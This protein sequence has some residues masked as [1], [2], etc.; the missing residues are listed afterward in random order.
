M[1]QENYFVS[2]KKVTC[3][4]DADLSHLEDLVSKDNAVIITD[5]H[6]YSGHSQKLDGWKTILIKPGEQYKQQATVEHL[7]S[8]LIELK[9]DRQTFIIGIGGGVVTD[10]TGYVASVY[11]RGVKFGFV[12]TTILAMTDAALGG[13]NGVDVGLYKNL[14]GTINQPEFLLYDY[15]FLS[16]LPA[17][18]WVNG[19]AEII[20]HAC[21]KDE[22]LF[23]Y[24]EENS[25]DF[26]KASPQKTDL[27]IKTNVAIKY[28][29]VTN[30]EYETGDRKL[31]NFG[32]TLGHA[33]EN[34]YTLPHGHAV[35]IGIAA[36]CTISEQL[37]NFPT[38]QTARIISLL[39]RYNLPVNIK[40]DKDKI[41]EMLLLD[42][43]KAKGSMNFILLNKIGEAIIK[44]IPL[45]QLHEIF[46]HLEL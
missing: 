16:T 36:A 11:M 32:H 9:A 5:E 12:P 44:P 19:F 41:W 31:L 33:I 25:I 18:Q 37:N 38:S 17:E 24:L 4:F 43:K 8:Q 22:K 26:F 42:K 23:S 21:I 39:K 6:V 40:F 30:D 3:Y 20:K 46:N 28:N 27:L 7:I 15:S 14:A 13:K 45:E 1:H 34:I 2:S 29:I 35:S 10:I